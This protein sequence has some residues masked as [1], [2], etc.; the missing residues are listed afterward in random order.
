MGR[1]EA[2]LGRIGNIGVAIRTV[3]IES[4]AAL[5]R[6]LAGAHAVVNCAGPFLDTADAVAAAAVRA[7]IPYF[8]VTAEQA[9]AQA[10]FERFDAAARDAGIVVVPAMGFYGGLGDLLATAAMGEWDFADEI[11]LGIALDSWRPTAGTRLTGE[12]NTARRFV[13]A[14]G[15]LTPQPLPARETSWRFPEPFGRQDVTEVPLSEIILIAQHL[16]VSQLHNYLNN[17]PLRD[18]GNPGT[19]PPV[20]ADESGRSPQMFLVDA[21]VRNGRETRRAVVRGRD[22]YAVTAPLVVEAVARVLDGRVQRHGALAPGELFD[23]KNFFEALA[24]E[25]LQFECNVPTRNVSPKN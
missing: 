22:I 3:S 20:A 11:N 1:D 18:L 4:P 21:I 24:P 14:D 7:R 25:H 15:K 2:K 9:S 10:T 23:A 8:D 5:D 17:I 12:R 19:P 13:V 6:A 16:R